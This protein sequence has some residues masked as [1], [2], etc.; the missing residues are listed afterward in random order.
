MSTAV[1]VASTAPNRYVP[2]SRNEFHAIFER[3]FTDFCDNYDE[4]YA[5]TYASTALSA[6]SKS[7][8]GSRRV[9]TICRASPASGVPTPTAG[10]TIFALA[11]PQSEH[12][13]SDMMFLAKLLFS[14]TRLPDIGD[15]FP[16]DMFLVY[17]YPYSILFGVAG[18]LK[19]HYHV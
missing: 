5:A 17:S 7:A 8:S 12:A 9:A 3:H 11:Q 15:R 10:M 6:S 2:R 16:G 4:K 1:T 18:H 19:N 14:S 13:P